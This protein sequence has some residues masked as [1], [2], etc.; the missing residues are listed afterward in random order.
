MLGSSQTSTDDITFQEIDRQDLNHRA[1]QLFDMGTVRMVLLPI[2]EWKCFSR[3]EG[4]TS[5]QV[6]YISSSQSMLTK[7][8]LQS[9]K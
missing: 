8:Y 6:R 2:D 9:K 7:R 4:P 3:H 1:T 5:C